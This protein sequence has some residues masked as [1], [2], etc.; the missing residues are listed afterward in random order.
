MAAIKWSTK[1]RNERR[2]CIIYGFQEFGKTTAIEFAKRLN[3]ITDMLV[4]HPLLGFIEPLLIGRSKQYR[5]YIIIGHLKLIYFYDESVDT[6][7]IAD[8]WNTY[9]SPAKLTIRLK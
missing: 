6:V 2:K 8:I 7:V 1:A 3:E 4:N 5:G 9:M